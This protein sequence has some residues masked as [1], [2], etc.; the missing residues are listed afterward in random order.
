MSN[1]T[2]SCFGLTGYILCTHVMN[3]LALRDG[4]GDARRP[5]LGKDG[6]VLIYL[7]NLFIYYENR[8]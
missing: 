3:S 4:S 1:S 2:M 5:A 6:T 8:T 7:F